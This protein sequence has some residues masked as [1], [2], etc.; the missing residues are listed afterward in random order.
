MTECIACRKSEEEENLIFDG[1]YF[2]HKEC[3]ENFLKI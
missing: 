1:G 3:R 2:F